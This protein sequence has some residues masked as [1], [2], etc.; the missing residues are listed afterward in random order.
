MT[1]C[2]MSPEMYERVDIG[3]RRQQKIVPPLVVADVETAILVHPVNKPNE[4]LR[5]KQ[6]LKLPFPVSQVLYTSK[7]SNVSHCVGDFTVRNG[8]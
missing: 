1:Y 5:G 2:G 4:R 3:R 7:Q 8:F 6:C